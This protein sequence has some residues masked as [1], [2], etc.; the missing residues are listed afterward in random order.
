M[1]DPLM[2]GST[3]AGMSWLPM[4]LLVGG[5]VAILRARKGG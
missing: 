2:G 5:A 3:Q 4:L 1:L